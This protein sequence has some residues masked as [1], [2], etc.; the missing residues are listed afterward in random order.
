MLDKYLRQVKDS[1]L[2]PLADTIGQRVHPTTI[3]VI[4]GGTG[5]LAAGVAWQGYTLA[6]L[7]LWA[8]NRVLDGLDGS[9]AR[10]TRRTSDFG[11][12]VDVLTDHVVYVSIPVGLALAQ[13]HDTLSL[14][15]VFMLATFYV[16]GASWMML[17]SILEK[18]RQRQA[19][20]VTTIIMPPGLIEGTETVIFYG[21]FFLL[22]GFLLELYIVFG[23]LVLLTI[24]QRLV[25]AWRHLDE[26]E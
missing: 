3:T 14:A 17:S 21:L 15:L 25:W 26:A 20:D 7:A 11:G 18:R 13:P 6:G 12:Y 16:N 1:L 10:R 5:L 19:D 4:G 23:V 2:N 9:L 8:A 22:P 24:I